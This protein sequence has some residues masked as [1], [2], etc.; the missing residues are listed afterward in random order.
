MKKLT[1]L[2][3]SIIIFSCNSQSQEKTNY[4]D[5]LGNCLNEKEISLL[6]RGCDLFEKELLRNYD[7]E[8]VGSSYKKFL[9]GFQ[10]MQIPREIFE[11]KETT[12]FL[13]SLKKSDLFQ[14]IWKK[15]EDENDEIIA[16][17]KPTEKEVIKKEKDYFQINEKGIYFNCLEEKSKNLKL[18]NFLKNLKD[19]PEISPGISAS[20]LTNQL[21][22][23]EFDSGIVRLIIAINFYYELKINL[24]E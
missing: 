10:T 12:E 2:I 7:N 21:N 4:A 24:S 15:Y 23:K 6:N 14:K 19:T 3:I 16:I 11:N 17:S 9:E 20:V 22:E 1:L 8:N 18:K 5:S 13:R